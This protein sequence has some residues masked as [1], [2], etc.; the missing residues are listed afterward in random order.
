M[1][2][3]VASAAAA[4]AA[5]TPEQ[6]IVFRHAKHHAPAAS[7][8]SACENYHTQC[9]IDK[10]ILDHC[11]EI[12][13]PEGPFDLTLA[14]RL[15]CALHSSQQQSP[16]LVRIDKASAANQNTWLCFFREEVSQQERN[17]RDAMLLTCLTLLNL[18]PLSMKEERYK[19]RKVLELQDI[20][21]HVGVGGK[22]K[23]ERVGAQRER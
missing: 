17:T 18:H 3:F 12:V 14:E 13:F 7:I 2:I 5:S 11:L 1:S 20:S 21:Y 6:P 10:D 9:I 16:S 19:G 23:A 8:L 4:A 15:E 22:K